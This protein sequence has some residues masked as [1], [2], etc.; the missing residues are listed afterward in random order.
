MRQL[1]GPTINM[2]QK[3]IDLRTRRHALI[4]SNIA[5]VD[6]P[7]YRAKDLPF[8]QVMEREMGG[9]QGDALP[10]TLTSA[11]HMDVSGSGGTGDDVP[12]SSEERGTPNNVDLD[13]EMA[14][15]TENYLQYQMTVQ[16]LVKEL[17]ILKTAITEG[18]K[19]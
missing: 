11:G 6:T 13:Q 9:G 10:M 7:G 14:K 2:L 5:N 8:R 18:G 3:A 1:F 16:A 15:L 12:V 4:T 17:D 19:A